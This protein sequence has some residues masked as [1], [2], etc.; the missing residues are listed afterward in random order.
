MQTHFLAL[1]TIL[2]LRRPSR[3]FPDQ[4]RAG[5]EFARSVM[6]WINGVVKVQ[7]KMN[8]CRIERAGGWPA[9]IEP[10]ALV[11]RNYSQVAPLRLERAFN[12]L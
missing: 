12:T 6:K 5:I 3:S 2:Y 4:D 7:S 10:L 8:H 9:L 1:Q 11:E